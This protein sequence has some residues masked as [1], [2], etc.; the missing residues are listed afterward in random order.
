MDLKRIPYDELLQ[1]ANTK[2]VDSLRRWLDRER[3]PYMLDSRNKP[4]VLWSSIANR[5]PDLDAKEEPI[6]FA[7]VHDKGQS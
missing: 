4:A 5:Y 1:F 7:P 6:G 3:I 2:Q